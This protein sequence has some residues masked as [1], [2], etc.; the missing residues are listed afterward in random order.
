MIMP[1]VQ[2]P[3]CRSEA[4]DR[5][6]LVPVGHHRKR[7]AGLHRFAVEMHHAGA[8]LRRVAADMGTGQ[9]EILAEELHQQRAGI[10]IGGYGITVHDE[11]NFGHHTL[12]ICAA[13]LHGKAVSKSIKRH[14]MSPSCNGQPHPGH[15]IAWLAKP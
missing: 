5:L 4:F 14:N 3:H 7:G 15:H 12:F 1:G 11:G 13:A 6:H 10:D 8:A 9:P 2:K